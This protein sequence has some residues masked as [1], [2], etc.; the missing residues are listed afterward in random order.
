MYLCFR[1][2]FLN[3]S[4]NIYIFFFAIIFDQSFC[5][6][7]LHVSNLSWSLDRKICFSISSRGKEYLFT[8]ARDILIKSY[9]A[10][11]KRK[12]D[13]R[14]ISTNLVN[15]LAPTRSMVC[16]K[17]NLLRIFILNQEQNWYVSQDCEVSDLE[18]ILTSNLRKIP[19]IEDLKTTQSPLLEDYVDKVPRRSVSNCYILKFAEILSSMLPH[20][21][22]IVGA[23]FLLHFKCC[24]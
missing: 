17:I 9:T 19:R 10:E 23:Y 21:Y 8:G 1:C 4:L 5:N 6:V 11:Y 7:T 22:S 20:R 18:R 3:N 13:Q 2:H 14:D 16:N 12:R 24:I 15:C